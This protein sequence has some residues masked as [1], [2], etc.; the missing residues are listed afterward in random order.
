MRPQPMAVRG[1]PGSAHA[2][3]PDEFRLAVLIMR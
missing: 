2:V 3:K 1:I